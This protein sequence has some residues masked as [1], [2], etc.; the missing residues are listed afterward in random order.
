MSTW[1]L[2][3][4]VIDMCG[5]CKSADDVEAIWAVMHEL[6]TCDDGANAYF[7]IY[8]RVCALE[9]LYNDGRWA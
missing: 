1:E 3:M 8:D 7:D 4:K 2:M 5:D 6:Y 9:D